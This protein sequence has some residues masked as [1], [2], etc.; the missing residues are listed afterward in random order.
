MQLRDR[1]GFLPQAI[2]ARL[3]QVRSDRWSLHPV[4]TRKS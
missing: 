4:D 3:T 1:D 2:Q